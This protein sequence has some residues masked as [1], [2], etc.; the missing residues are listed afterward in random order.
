M[1]SKKG[2]VIIK[3]AVK[4]NGKINDA[5]NLVN[6]DVTEETP[7]TTEVESAEV[8]VEETATEEN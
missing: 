8:E 7:E 2:L 1:Q 3:S 4:A 6:Y 5:E